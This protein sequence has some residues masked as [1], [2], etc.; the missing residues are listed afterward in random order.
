[1]EKNMCGCSTPVFFTLLVQFSASFAS[2]SSSCYCL[3]CKR[4]FGGSQQLLLHFTTFLQSDWRKAA[5]YINSAND[6]NNTK[7]LRATQLHHHKKL[8]RRI[9]TDNAANQWTDHFYLWSF[10]RSRAEDKE[11]HLLKPPVCCRH[12][13]ENV[14]TCRS[15]G[16]Q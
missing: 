11:E 10:I 14:V 5:P 3:C 8:R 9:E 6:A 12:R 1:M 7:N 2:S 15:V 16:Q 13:R 4:G